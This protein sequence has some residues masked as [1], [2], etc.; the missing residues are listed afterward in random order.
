MGKVLICWCLCGP[1]AWVLGCCFGIQHK[2]LE[3]KEG[4]SGFLQCPGQLGPK[5]CYV[6]DGD[7]THF[8]RSLNLAIDSTSFRSHMVS[9]G[10]SRKGS[11][12]KNTLC[13]LHQSVTRIRVWAS[14]DLHAWMGSPWAC[15]LTT[16]RIFEASS[17]QNSRW[18]KQ[19]QR[20]L[21]HIIV[22]HNKYSKMWH[23]SMEFNVCL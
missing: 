12:E 11:T 6:N 15:L 22:G 2:L 17:S 10:T 14:Q 19:S 18:R 1:Y 3:M 4:T 8:L 7:K 21:N 16:K 23:L 20:L 9:R 5:P 13:F